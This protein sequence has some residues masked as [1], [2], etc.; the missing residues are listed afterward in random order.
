M[1]DRIR[2]IAC[3]PE[4]A[5]A[6]ARVIRA[7]ADAAFPAGGS[8]CAQVSRATLLETA[9]RCE[10]HAGGALSLRRRQLPVLRGAVRW[11]LSEDGPADIN[12]PADLERLF[13]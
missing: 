2:E 12:A 13:D 3:G 10:Q 1:K 9:A 4:Q 5:R 11:A 8:E 6:I 7:Y